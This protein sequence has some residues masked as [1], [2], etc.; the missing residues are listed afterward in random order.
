MGR[1]DVPARNYKT[2]SFDLKG[3]DF[4]GGY[5]LNLKWADGHA[6]GIYPY[7][8]LRRLSA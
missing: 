4:V 5:G 8:H 6:T 7:Q 3:Y 1:G 2:G